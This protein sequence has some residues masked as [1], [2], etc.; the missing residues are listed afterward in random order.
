LLSTLVTFVDRTM[1]VL[2]RHSGSSSDRKGKSLGGG[3]NHH[4]EETN[5][6]TLDR[7]AEDMIDE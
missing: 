2:V 4:Q 5:D 3:G 1:T 6:D 7:E